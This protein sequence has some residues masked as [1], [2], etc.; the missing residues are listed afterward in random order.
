MNILTRTIKQSLVILYSFVLALIVVVHL[1]D[2]TVSRSDTFSESGDRFHGER[3][4]LKVKT[5]KGIFQRA[6]QRI[7]EVSLKLERARKN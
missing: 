6:G 2:S 3:L 1:I 7:R 5:W 4:N